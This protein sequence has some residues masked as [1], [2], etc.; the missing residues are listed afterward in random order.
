[1][2]L[3]IYLVSQA[4]D[5]E[6]S[7]RTAHKAVLVIAF[8]IVVGLALFIPYSVG[9]LNTRTPSCASGR[10]TMVGGEDFC[11]RDVTDDFA[12]PNPGFG[13]ILNGSIVYM[14]VKFTTVCPQR[15]SQCGASDSN[16]TTPLALAVEIT[17]SFPDGAQQTIGG[18]VG[19]SNQFTAISTQVDPR[20]GVEIRYQSQTYVVLL[21]VQSA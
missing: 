3:R 15:P 8:A 13:Y 19:D 17:L 21:L 2:L 10:Q 6:I 16:T 18:V 14:G 9:L 5:S 7:P 4:S 1:M 20:A 12:L 11:L